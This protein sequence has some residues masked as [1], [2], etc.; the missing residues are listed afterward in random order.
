VEPL[1]H[2]PGGPHFIS[3]D[4]VAFLGN[5]HIQM[6]Q[7]WAKAG[8]CFIKLDWT[9]PGCNYPKF[10]TR[11]LLGMAPGHVSFSGGLGWAEKTLKAAQLLGMTNCPP[12][13]RQNLPVWNPVNIP[14]GPKL[15]FQPPPLPSWHGWN[16]GYG[17]LAGPIYV[18][19][20]LADDEVSNFSEAT[21]M[22]AAS[23]ASAVC[24]E[25]AELADYTFS[26]SFPDHDPEEDDDDRAQ[27][28]LQN[29]LLY[30][31]RRE[32]EMLY[33][34]TGDTNGLLAVRASAAQFSGAWHSF[35]LPRF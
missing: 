27:Q 22:T 4:L 11:H 33:A 31:Q 8:E 14:S 17:T 15:P 18:S 13:S 10:T 35:G 6:V 21:S 1:S 9:F 29:E 25:P 30:R 26:G 20:G 2:D 28:Q 34:Q 23:D 19:R 3:V 24:S 32:A 7:D 12:P 5:C 16:P